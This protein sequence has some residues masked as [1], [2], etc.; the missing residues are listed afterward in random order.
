MKKMI[1]AICLLIIVVGVTYVKVVRGTSQR[2][3]SR[4][5][6]KKE[7]TG[8]LLAYRQAVDSLQYLIEQQEIAFR[9]S[10]SHRDSAYQAGI[11]SLMIVLDSMWAQAGGEVDSTQEESGAPTDAEIAEEAA[12]SEIIAFYEKLYQGLPNDLSKYER[13]VALHEIRLETAQNFSIS[14]N[15][16]KALR[17]QY[18]LTY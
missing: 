17:S 5:E 8:E 4:D 6:G 9:D 1:V 13:K 10:L 15:E 14:L 3:I 7:A 16:L 2:Q 12:H 11:D 18:E